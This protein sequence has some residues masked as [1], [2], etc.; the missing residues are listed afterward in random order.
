MAQRRPP[1]LLRS[2]GGGGPAM[3]G[4]MTDDLD[5]LTVRLPKKSAADLLAELQAH[6]AAGAVLPEPTT[7]PEP[8]FPYQLSHPLGGTVRFSCPRG[9]GWHH[10]EHPDREKATE[11]LVLPLDLEQLDKA[12]TAQAEAQAEA[13]RARIEGAI[14]T[15]LSRRTVAGEAACERCQCPALK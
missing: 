10:D 8:E 2:E 3:L 1:P 12:L 6:R 14:A 7:I 5:A 13:F 4:L 9:C 15:A 11:R